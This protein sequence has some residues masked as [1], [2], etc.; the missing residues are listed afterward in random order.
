MSSLTIYRNLV[1]GRWIEPCA[2]FES[3][4]P[5]TG[6]PWALIPR[7]GTTQIDSAVAAARSAFF[8]GEWPAMTSS[9]R[10]RLLMRLA[11]LIEAEARR[12]AA[13]ETRDNG[14]L[15]A[16]TLVQLRYI[17]E[18]YRY[19]GGLADKV[20][21]RVLPIDK[22]G[23]VAYTRHEPLG[24]VAAII[25]WN[26][27]LQLL[28]WKLAPLL[29]AGN[30]V[31]IKPS[32][33]ASVSTLAFV[34]LFEQAGFPPGVVNTVTGFADEAGAP[35]AGHQHVA[36]I[37]FTGGEAGGVAIATAAARDIKHTTLELGGKS[38]NIVF[39]DADLD[40]AASGVVA[41]IFAASGQ[42]CIAGSRLL[43]ERRVHDALVDRIAALATSAR[44]GDPAAAD[45][46]IG[47]ITTLAQKER[48]LSFIE[49]A[50]GEGANI[51][52]GGK[53]P[54]G[55]GWFIEPTILTQVDNRMRVAREEIFGPVLS[56]IPFDDEDEAIA[57]AND[58]PYGLAAGVWTSDMGKAFRA[59]ERLRVGMIWIN[60][61][62]AVSYMAPFGGSKRSGLGREN[63]QEAI[64]SY[65]QTKTVWI[66]PVARC[67]EPFVIR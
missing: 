27:P 50:V 65:L 13:I 34:E 56:V 35:L 7:D 26:S 45:T 28:T 49:I 11:D 21:G 64:Y 19:F 1:G 54:D 57:V 30:T 37:A 4:D 63:G 33:H 23:M 18:W 29:A 60:S 40:A 31:V 55:P 17:P 5:N 62:R 52:I 3:F 2:T 67:A 66:D 22:P 8:A 46:Q 59:I 44:L 16:E 14:K 20:E 32:E 10:G 15:L 38:A 42:T 41:G 39:A 9:A 36:K 53:S 24:V 51:H 61:Y 43:V 12:L 58:S 25:P 48:I 6:Q 47:P